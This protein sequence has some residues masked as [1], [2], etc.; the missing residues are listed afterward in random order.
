MAD[1]L[2]VEE[3]R[4][5][6]RKVREA[7]HEALGTLGGSA[8]RD[9]VAAEALRVGEFS[10]AEL[11]APAPHRRTA[12]GHE[13][14]LDYQLDWALTRLERDGLLTEPAP[15]GR[16]SRRTRPRLLRRALSR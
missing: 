5:L 6:A 14:L 11:E 9:A 13:R 12:D 2:S 1:R 10:A 15:A 16:K 7:A 4:A 3:R 8:G